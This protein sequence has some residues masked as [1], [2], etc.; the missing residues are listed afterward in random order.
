MLTQNQCLKKASDMAAVAS[1]SA[2]P[3][4]RKAYEE[5]AL[6][7]SNIAVMAETQEKLSASLG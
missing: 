3:I 6:Q 5:L 4:Q 1:M 7:W 2:D